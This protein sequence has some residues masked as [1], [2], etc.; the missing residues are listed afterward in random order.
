MTEPVA[1]VSKLSIQKQNKVCCFISLDQ[2]HHADTTTRPAVPANKFTIQNLGLACYDVRQ[3]LLIGLLI[4]A[5]TK[6]TFLR[7]HLSRYHL[8]HYRWPQAAF[9]VIPPLGCV[10][11]VCLVS[12]LVCAQCPNCKEGRTVPHR[13][14]LE[15]LKHCILELLCSCS[16][17]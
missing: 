3:V 7:Y 8:L 14:L 10:S 16:L 5:H 15:Q 1:V 2:L 12:Y 9:S 4:L 11:S 6:A 13:R 17:L